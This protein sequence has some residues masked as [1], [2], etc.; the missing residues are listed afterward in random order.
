MSGNTILESKMAHAVNVYS[1][2]YFRAFQKGRFLQNDLTDSREAGNEPKPMKTL[3][4]LILM[5]FYGPPGHTLFEGN[6][7]VKSCY[8]LLIYCL[9]KSK[10]YGEFCVYSCVP[11]PKLWGHSKNQDKTHSGGEKLRF[12]IYPC[13]G[14]CPDK[15]I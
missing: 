12:S 3:Y 7:I 14:I 8:T 2:V 15:V 6:S 4:E 11:R 5:N 10:L 13:M 1:G 9:D